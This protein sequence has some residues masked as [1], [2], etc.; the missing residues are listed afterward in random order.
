MDSSGSIGEN[1][2]LTVLD[3]TKDMVLAFPVNPTEV[4]FGVVTYGNRATVEFYLNT[5]NDTG[6]YLAVIDQIGWKDQA[7]NTSGGIHLMH[8][9]LF[10]EANGDR[11]GIPNIGIVV[12]D[13]ASNRD[14]E[15]DRT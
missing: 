14:E 15:S 13:G 4:R 7:T 8:S 9:E 1:N 6:S 5:H 2:W 12:T 10:T 3:F 11:P